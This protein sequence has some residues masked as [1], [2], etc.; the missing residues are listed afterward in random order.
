[1]TENSVTF[2]AVV[3]RMNNGEPQFMGILQSKEK[4]DADIAILNRHGQNWTYQVV[5]FLGWGQVAPGVFS[6]NGP[7]DLKVVKDSQ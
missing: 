3:Y 6:Q 5:P 2:G 4:A 7:P 1:M